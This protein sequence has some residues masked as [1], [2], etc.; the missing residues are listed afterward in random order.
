M[1]TNWSRRFKTNVEKIKSGD[2]YQVAEVVRNL[3]I[4]EKAKGL[5]AGE[6][7]MLARARQILV[8]ELTFAFDHP[9]SGRGDARQ[10]ARRGPLAPA[11]PTHSESPEA[12][13]PRLACS[14]SIPDVPI[15]KGTVARPLLACARLDQLRGA[16][17]E[18]NT[19]VETDEENKGDSGGPRPRRGGL[20]VEFVRLIWV[21]LFAMRRMEPW[22][23]ARARSRRAGSRS[24]SSSGPPSA[25]SS[26]GISAGAPP[27]AASKVEREF[28][29]IP[30]ARDPRRVRWGWSWAL[31]AG[32]AAVDP[33][34]PP[35]AHRGVSTVGSALLRMRGTLGTRWAAPRATSCS[36]SS[37]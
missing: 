24:A 26:A 6:K 17:W 4:R 31:V 22:G 16:P 1:P 5:S 29:R 14:S 23:R 34:L 33:H 30:A 15:L 9:R 27:P 25:S 37:A 10:G 20:L 35:S 18:R 19:L 3:S 21:A 32:G 13:R 36:R 8:S 7:R 28:R 12:L 11:P 2:I